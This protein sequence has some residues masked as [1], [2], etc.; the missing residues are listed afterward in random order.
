MRTSAVFL[1]SLAL[2]A[3]KPHDPIEVVHNAL[4]KLVEAIQRLP[5]YT[6][7]QTVNRTYYRQNKARATCDETLDYK[8]SGYLPLEVTATDRLRLDVAVS[9]TGREIYS[10]P[11]AGLFE[12]RSLPELIGSGPM[13]TGPFGPFLLAIFGNKEVH[14]FYQGEEAVGGRSR[15][16]Y[17]FK[18]PVELSRYELLLDGN[19]RAIPFD[20]TFFLGRES[21]ELERLLVHTTAFQAGLR[22][23]D[24]TTTVDFTRQKIGDTDYL[25]PRES[26]LYAIG[27]GTETENVTT[28]S[29]CRVYRAESVIRFDDETAARPA[30]SAANAQPLPAGLPV[31]LVLDQEIDTDRAAAGDLVIA[32][33]REPIV[34]PQ[35][36]QVLALAGARA[37]GRITRMEH[38]TVAP[39]SFRIAILFETLESAG[40]TSPFS[41]ELDSKAGRLGEFTISASELANAQSASAAALRINTDYSAGRTLVFPTGKTR[42]VVPKGYESRWVTAK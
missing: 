13:G 16:G 38:H 9:D 36:K 37:H 8:R 10:W 25:L 33:L 1:V 21:S 29:S 14:Y 23:C 3:Q 39:A 40:V 32:K 26:R 7:V 18:V 42:H 31:S 35:S 4:P 20:G 19:R 5:N 30:P 24:A 28:W 17:R 2:F 6:C 41:V 27:I 15:L 22:V 11:E 34:E 12:S